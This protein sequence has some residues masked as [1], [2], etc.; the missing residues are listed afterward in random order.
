MKILV[1]TDVH[2]NLSCLEALANT[3]DFKS[4]DKIIFLGDVIIGC[5]R[6]NECINFLKNINCIK[7]LGNNDFYISRHIPEVDM[8]EFSGE[9]LKQAE[10][11]KSI[12]TYE[13][14]KEILSWEMDYNLNIDNIKFYFT[15]YAWENYNNDVNV[16]DSPIN[17]TLQ[18]REKAFKD[19]DTDYIIFGHEH[20]SNCFFGENKVYYCL[21]SLGLKSPSGYLL[22][23]IENGE[24]KLQEKQIKHDINYEIELMDKAGYPYEKSKIKGNK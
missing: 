2:G 18:D 5:S 1:F 13:N 12:L 9:K 10:Y 19:I 14:K 16:V 20:K 17:P 15:H 11:M 3:E 24:V 6:P 8:T 23:E 22:I 21:G 4:A 7:I